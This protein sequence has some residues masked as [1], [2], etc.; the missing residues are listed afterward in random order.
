MPNEL[1]WFLFIIVD[2]FF[3]IIAFYIWGKYGLYA[4]IAIGTLICNIQVTKTIQMFGLVATLGNVVYASLFFNTDILSEIYGKKEAKRAVWIGFYTLVSATVAMQFA[5]QFKPHV[6][7]VMHP[8]LKAIFDFMPR[9][10]LASLA[11][12]IISQ[13]HDIWAFHFWKKTTRGKWLWLRNNLS[14]M[15]S[16]LIDTT[17]FT[18]LAFW[19]VFSLP[20][21]WQIFLTTYLFKWMIAAVDTPFLYLGRWL[22]QRKKASTQ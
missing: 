9:V 1:L 19:G 14:T 2:L 16:Q 20:V 18:F 3:S 5:V 13:H 22:Y 10:V 15:V 17:V 8:H 11:A 7:D 21:F 4:M 6:S 12:Y